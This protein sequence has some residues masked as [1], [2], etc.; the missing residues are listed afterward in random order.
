M[1]RGRGR[2]P[3]Y[4]DP[5][6]AWTVPATVLAVVLGALGCGAATAL[7]AAVAGGPLGSGRLAVFGPVWWLVGGAAALWTASVALPVTLAVRAWRVRSGAGGGVEPGT[8]G[9]SGDGQGAAAP[10]PSAPASS[11]AAPAVAAVPGEGWDDG[12][13]EDLDDDLEPYDFLPL[14]AW[15][16]RAAAVPAPPPS[17]VPTGPPPPAP[18]PSRLPQA[19]PGPQPAP[20]APAPDAPPSAAE[21]PPSHPDAPA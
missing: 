11:A 13:L 9:G 21:T 17:A 1:A 19:A 2:G 18:G 5:D 16:E 3:R 8:G 6:Q 20:A 10:A 15:A 4:G 14:D 7:L 12:S